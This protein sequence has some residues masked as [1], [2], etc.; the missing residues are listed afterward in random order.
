MEP[1]KGLLRSLGDTSAAMGKPLMQSVEA[2]ADAI[3]GENERLKEFGIKARKG[4]GMIAYEY[5]DKN[6]KTVVKKVKAN[7]RELIQATLMGIWNNKY[8]GA[9]EK[10]SKTFAGMLS[11]I[12]D[13][14][15]RFELMV[16]GSGLFDMMKDEVSGVLD[17]LNQMANDGS[18][19]KLAQSVGTELKAMFVELKQAAIEVWPVLKQIGGT[20][21]A[22]A[23]NL[24]GYG[25]LL[26]VIV[27]AMAIPVVVSY[28]QSIVAGVGL[29]NAGLGLMG[30]NWGMIG[31]AVVTFGRLL[32]TALAPFAPALITITAIGIAGTILY[33]KWTPFKQL[34]DRIVSNLKE[35]P[36]LLNYATG[37]GRAT[38]MD[39]SKLNPAARKRYDAIMAQK[40][41][42]RAIGGPVRAGLAYTVGE[43]GQE[44]FIP[45]Q[46][47]RILNQRQ[48]GGR[49][50]LHITLTIDSKGMPQVANVESRTARK[51][52]VSTNK[53]ARG[54]MMAPG[55]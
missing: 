53:A 41:G 16:M 9:M 14:F 29:I 3:T 24:G 18:M 30:L 43:F 5:T 32:L 17:S 2:I 52:V 4:G 19:K 51:V 49:D 11:N 55:Y 26:K 1:T 44:T 36:A 48:M 50:E 33:N 38:V 10:Q 31:T 46:S 6:G 23:K 37:G 54:P 34:V 40:G 15:T 42:K 12:S 39:T 13:A 28:I 21:A 8:A 27:A 35:V 22:L 25:N 45:N 47:G 20:I 7:N